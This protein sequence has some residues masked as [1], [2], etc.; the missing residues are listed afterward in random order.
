MNILIRPRNQG[1]ALTL[2]LLTAVVIGFTLAS[3]LTLVSSQNA[4]VMRSLSWNHAMSVA[5]AGVEE[6]LTQLRYTGTNNLLAHDWSLLDN[7]Y[8]F[9]QRGLG[10][11]VYFEVGIKPLERP[12]IISFGYVPA[13]LSPASKL[14][15][16]LGQTTLASTQ[17]AGYLK[18]KVRVNAKR[19]P[20][21]TKAML[22]KGQIN[23]NGNKVATDSFDSTDPKASTNGKYNPAL[24]RDNGDV[25]TNS[26]LID[27]LDIGNANIR[28]KVSTGPTGSVSVGSNGTVGSK[29]WVAAG[30][31]GI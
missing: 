12:V 22:A 2:T 3:Y 30:N 27:S 28:G 6:A 25:A 1:G 29:D 7:G 24:A 17:P 9:K 21:F 10:N 20:I 23:L 31:R 16:I 8:Y 26:G 14:G 13:P 4:S 19:D 18:R 5:E 15:M 11:N